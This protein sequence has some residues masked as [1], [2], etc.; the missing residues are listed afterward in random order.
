[1]R[2]VLALALA[3]GLLVAWPVAASADS[4]PVVPSGC[5]LPRIGDAVAGQLDSVSPDVA[6]TVR[7]LVAANCGPTASAATTPSAVAGLGSFA[8]L[9]RP[10]GGLR[11]GLPVS[12]YRFGTVAM[13]NYGGVPAVAP[14]LFAP[15]PDQRYGMVPVGSI[16]LAGGSDDGDLTAGSAFVLDA[17]G[18]AGAVGMPLLL[19]V[20]A[21]SGVTAALVRTWASRRSP[22]R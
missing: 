2:R 19:A 16:A 21:L 7:Q 4:L 11:G 14:G 9:D 8:G 18:F 20:L 13:R 17:G 5:V 10:I 3:G 22:G 15:A 6:S 1:V 12:L